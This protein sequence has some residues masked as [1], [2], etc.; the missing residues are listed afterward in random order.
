MSNQVLWLNMM[1]EQ[2][3]WLSVMMNVLMLWLYR[4]CVCVCVCDK[5]HHIIVG[6]GDWRVSKCCV[7]IQGVTGEHTG[8]LCVNVMSVWECKCVSVMG[9]QVLWVKVS[10]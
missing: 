7:W 6:G 9:E 3:S 5:W 4:V 2:V 1:S 8:L 10:R